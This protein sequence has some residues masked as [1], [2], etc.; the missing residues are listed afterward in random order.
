MLKDPM[1]SY[2]LTI[3]FWNIFT[4]TYLS[5]PKERWIKFLINF[6]LILQLWNLE[7]YT[8]LEM[9]CLVCHTPKSFLEFFNAELSM[10]AVWYKIWERILF[11]GLFRS[12]WNLK[13][14][15]FKDDLKFK[16]WNCIAQKHSEKININIIYFQNILC[17]KSARSLYNG[18]NVL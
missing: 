16:L 14:S 7:N 17:K 2:F 13:K 8:F 1:L 15:L 11:L 18:I 4:K 12:L 5:R 9:S 3:N 10:T 6:E